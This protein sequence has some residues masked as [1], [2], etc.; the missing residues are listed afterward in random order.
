ML[1]AYAGMIPYSTEDTSISSCAPRIR[2][3]DPGLT[4]LP[5]RVLSVLPAY[6]GM[7]PAARACRHAEKRAPRIRGDDPGTAGEP[8]K[9][10]GCSPHTRG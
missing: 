1:P 3:D 5:G 10:K 6:A 9:L 4:S 2:G 7:I 8:G